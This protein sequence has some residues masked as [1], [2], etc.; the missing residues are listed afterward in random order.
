MQYYADA[1]RILVEDVGGVFIYHTNILELRKPWV[2]G[3]TPN[4]WGQDLFW[5]NRTKLM[6][7]YIGNNVEERVR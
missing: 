2:K 6:D 7:M 1:E 3:L 4:A 5:G